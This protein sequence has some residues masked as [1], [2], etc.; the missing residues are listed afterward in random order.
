[1]LKFDTDDFQ[2]LRFNY[3]SLLRKP[4]KFHRPTLVILYTILWSTLYPVLSIMED[5]RSI[6]YNSF[7]SQYIQV[8]QVCFPLPKFIS[9]RIKR[10]ITLLFYESCLCWGLFR[11]E[12]V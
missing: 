6:L 12:I 8:T 1:M 5:N 2:D 7:G 9:Q 3:S 4:I 10:S 11:P